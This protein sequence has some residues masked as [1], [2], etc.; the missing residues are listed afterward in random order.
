M[1]D[2]ALYEVS[3]GNLQCRWHGTVHSTY[4]ASLSVAVFVVAPR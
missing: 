3:D 2:E 4:L 1:P